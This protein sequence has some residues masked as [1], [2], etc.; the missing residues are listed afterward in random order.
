[1]LAALLTGSAPEGAI[2]LNAPQ[3]EY[4]I[5]QASAT[6]S[7]WIDANGWRILRAS[8]RTFVY[9]VKG[10]AAAL[11]AAESFTYGAGALISTDSKGR[12]RSLGCSGC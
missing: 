2:V 5:T 4:H 12:R 6:N 8:G 1:M 3:V 11:A 7:P 9:R 10:E